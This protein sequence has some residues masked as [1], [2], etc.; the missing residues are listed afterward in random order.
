M[1]YVFELKTK[2]G[3][4]Y[5]YLLLFSGNLTTTQKLSYKLLFTINDSPSE[6]AFHHYPTFL[7]PEGYWH[8]S[9]GYRYSPPCLGTPIPFEKRGNYILNYKPF[10]LLIA[11]LLLT[12]N[13][14]NFLVWIQERKIFSK[15]KKNWKSF[16]FFL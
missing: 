1:L 15:I 2:I 6:F 4:H 13:N 9:R 14:K 16:F 7:R 8:S 11:S 5:T 12:D 10:L 3:K